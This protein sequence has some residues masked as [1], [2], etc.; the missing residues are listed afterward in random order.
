MATS[1]RYLLLPAQHLGPGFEVV[2]QTE[3][4]DSNGTSCHD[5]NQRIPRLL[6][7]PNRFQV[8]L[9]VLEPDKSSAIDFHNT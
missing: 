2:V 8:H 5:D 7:L 4:G 6:A 9:N 3:Q 1:K